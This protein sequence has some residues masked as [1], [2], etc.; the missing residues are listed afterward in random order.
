[1]KQ[2]NITDLHDENERHDLGNTGL[3]DNKIVSFYLSPCWMRTRRKDEC[4]YVLQP[5]GELFTLLP[6]MTECGVD[7]DINCVQLLL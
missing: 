4:M 5:V 1:M 6:H 3:W 7:I 2:G